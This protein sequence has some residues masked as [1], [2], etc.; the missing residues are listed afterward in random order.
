MK[1]LFSAL[2]LLS[3]S[4]A[5]FASPAVSYSCV[6]RNAVTKEAV[7]FEVLFAESDLEHGYMNQAVSITKEGWAVPEEPSTYQMY[8]AT[9]ENACQKTPE[10]EVYMHGDFEMLPTKKN[11]VG[12][13]NATFKVN[14]GER[15]NYDVKG[16]CFYEHGF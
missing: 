11:A 12:D 16:V 2:A 6:G 8:G 7:T 9:K 3:L 1:I 5:A 13:F 14:C 4:P 15:R 10:G